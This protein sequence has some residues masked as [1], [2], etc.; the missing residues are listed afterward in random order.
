[1]DFTIY[2]VHAKTEKLEERTTLFFIAVS[3]HHIIIMND[4]TVAVVITGIIDFTDTY[5]VLPPMFIIYCSACSIPVVILIRAARKCA[6]H[7]NCRVLIIFWAIS[8]LAILIDITLVSLYS[9]TYER[10]YLHRSLMEPFFRPYLL[11][12]HS[13]FYS[14]GSGFEMFIALERILSTLW[15]H[16]YHSS[17]LNPGFLA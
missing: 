12:C 15:P 11:V 1:D 5:P 6:L 17:G 13:V 8:L 10:G 2:F 9:L 3:I 16:V 4:S 14:G 7:K